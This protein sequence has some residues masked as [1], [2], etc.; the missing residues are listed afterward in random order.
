MTQLRIEPQLKGGD[1]RMAAT[2]FGL[3]G[4]AASV[5]VLRYLNES[6]IE[7]ITRE[8][9]NVGP[10]PLEEE[11]KLAEALYREPKEF[12][13]G[14]N[15]GPAD[16]DMLPVSRVVELLAIPWGAQS[17][18][19]HDKAT[20]PHEAM[21]LRL[22]SQKAERALRWRGRV[23]L[24]RAL[25]WT[26]NWFRRYLAGESAR[27]LCLSQIDEYTTLGFQAPETE[28]TD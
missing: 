7:K 8:I 17:A 23:P 11:E 9:S 19:V 21:E 27:R 2:L 22:N 25:E 1:V 16:A 12:G 5:E 15:F 4:E 26:S 3:M 13:G 18:W 28:S 14:W 6:E 20:Y 24:I 10:V